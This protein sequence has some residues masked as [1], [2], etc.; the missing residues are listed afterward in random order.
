M[1]DSAASALFTCG[2]YSPLEDPKPEMLPP[3]FWRLC[4]TGGAGKEAPKELMLES[5]ST[6]AQPNWIQQPGLCTLILESYMCKHLW[7]GF[8]FDVNW[9]RPTPIHTGFSSSW[10]SSAI[11]GKHGVSFEATVHYHIVHS[12]AVLGRE[13]TPPWRQLHAGC[14]LK[15][16]LGAVERGLSSSSLWKQCLDCKEEQDIY[17]LEAAVLRRLRETWQ[18]IEEPP[19]LWE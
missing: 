7:S 1:R 8:S 6:E 17:L 4:Y 14:S 11:F 10:G 16:G 15:G 5:G 13:Y 9:H 2:Y 3:Q 19:Y 18:A 12:M